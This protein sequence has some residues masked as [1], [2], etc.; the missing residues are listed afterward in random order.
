[1]TKKFLQKELEELKNSC[2]DSLYWKTPPKRRSYLVE[3]EEKEDYYD[4]IVLESLKNYD[5]ICGYKVG[6]KVCFQKHCNHEKDIEKEDQ[7]KEKREEAKDN[8]LNL[9]IKALEM[10]I[11]K[12]DEIEKQE[13]IELPKLVPYSDSERED[14]IYDTDVSISEYEE[15]ELIKGQV[16]MYLLPAGYKFGN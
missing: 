12:E 1:M 6:K 11:P 2:Q 14:N 4:N 15:E 9:L 16:P 13:D 10:M 8:P 7:N 5:N 3:Y